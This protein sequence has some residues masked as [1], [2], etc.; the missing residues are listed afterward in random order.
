MHLA[1]FTAKD[2]HATC[3]RGHFISEQRGCKN[4]KAFQKRRGIRMVM[5]PLS[6]SELQGSSGE[7]M[8]F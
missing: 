8:I 6:D 2:K 3:L 1:A 4:E 7:N 5:Q